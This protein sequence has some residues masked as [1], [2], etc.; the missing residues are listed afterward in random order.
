MAVLAFLFFAA[1]MALSFWAMIATVRPQLTR[2]IDL[3]INGPV[4]AMSMPLRPAARG[5]LRD[6]RISPV[7]CRPAPAA[8]RVAA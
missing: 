8:L 3:L 2:I 4:Q 6:V 7:H 5:G 1:V